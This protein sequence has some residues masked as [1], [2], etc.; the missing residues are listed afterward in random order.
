MSSPK[1][2]TEHVHQFVWNIEGDLLE[3]FKL[4]ECE[5]VFDSNVFFT[6]GAQWQ[7]RFYPKGNTIEE[8]EYASLFIRCK[9]FPPS[10]NALKVNYL[11]IVNDDYEFH[12]NECVF[13]NT[14]HGWGKDSIM[15]NKK[16]QSLKSLQI[17]CIIQWSMDDVNGFNSRITST[18]EK[19]QI[20][21]KQKAIEMEL[22]KYKNNSYLRS[23]VLNESQIQEIDTH[24]QSKIMHEYNA[25]L[26]KHRD[27][28]DNWNENTNSLNN[29]ITNSNDASLLEQYIESNA[30]IN[31]QSNRLSKVA[32]DDY[33]MQLLKK[34]NA[35]QVQTKQAEQL[36]LDTKKQLNEIVKQYES[37]RDS[38]IKLQSLIEEQMCKLN[39]MIE[40]EN[41][42]LMEKKKAQL[43]S[44]TQNDEISQLR[45]L[46]EKNISL[47]NT[48][49]DFI[50]INKINI[51]KAQLYFK[52]KWNKFENNWYEWTSDDI[53]AWFKYK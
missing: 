24:A 28:L 37:K 53:I 21:E 8:N 17:S 25:L 38:R 19:K 33:L 40:K 48:Y 9:K 39:D 29:I 31:E 44:D 20:E 49:N 46:T 16:L 6:C 32:T 7:L 50:Q 41:E 30:L 47:I 13:E 11:F 15:A 45:S 14:T 42:L 43:K 10:K 51:D 12:T 18:H 35:I 27:T 4:A 5:E 23:L 26:C 52:E 3:S 22:D 34:Q 36:A 1:F 2:D